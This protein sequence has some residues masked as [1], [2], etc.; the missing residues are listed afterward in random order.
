MEKTFLLLDDHHRGG[1]G[2]LGPLLCGPGLSVGWDQGRQGADKGR[3]MVVSS[4]SGG[5]GS[6]GWLGEPV[7]WCPKTLSITS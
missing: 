2:S 1:F 4:V 3:V 7:S 5:G 6:R